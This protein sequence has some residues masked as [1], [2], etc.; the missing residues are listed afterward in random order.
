MESVKIS[1][2]MIIKL[3]IE[4]KKF[5][6]VGDEFVVSVVGDSLRLKKVKKPDMLDLAASK[7]DKKAPTLEDI[8][9]IIHAI[10]GA[11]ETKGSH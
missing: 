2:D 6:S 11:G 3:P 7:K 9:K 5:V 1:K 10:R 8:S 4:M